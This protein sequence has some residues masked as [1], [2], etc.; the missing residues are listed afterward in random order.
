MVSL[1]QLLGVKELNIEG[2][3]LIGIV[4]FIACFIA[5]VINWGYSAYYMIKTIG[6]FH[7]DREW[8]KYIAFSLFIPWF[9]TEE[10]NMY[11]KHL[12]KHA[13]YFV[14]LCFAGMAIG[15]TQMY[16]FPDPSQPTPENV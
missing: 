2:V 3:E 14:L 12:L 1:I 11:R 10:G 15:Y 6:N 13:G 4:L 9:F 7:P 5:A 8:G 16:F